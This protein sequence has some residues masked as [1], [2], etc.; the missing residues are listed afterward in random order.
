VKILIQ[1]LRHVKASEARTLTAEIPN[2][3]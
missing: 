3:T 1:P 2:K